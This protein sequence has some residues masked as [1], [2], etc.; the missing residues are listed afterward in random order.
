VPIFQIGLRDL[1]EEAGEDYTK[2]I[3]SS[4]YCPH[5]KDVEMFLHE[6][7]IE[8]AKR[9]FSSTYLVF[10]SYKKEKVLA[11]YY[12]IATKPIDV[13]K[14]K[15]SNTLAKKIRY[16]ATY[17]DV[18]KSYTASFGLIAQLGKN[19]DKGYDKLIT[20]D[21]L[22]KLAC[23]KVREIQ[24]ASSGKFVYLECE[25]KEKLIQFYEDNGFV[26]FGERKLDSEELNYFEEK[27]LMQLLKEL[28]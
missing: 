24:I 19:Y 23:D 14:K 4:Y 2:D 1:I 12:T 5:N 22:L 13:L 28:K 27:Y 17:N 20:G 6:K 26:V 8:F 21:E 7:A 3:L 10:I 15:I 18:S 16:H 25:D 9:R 11:G